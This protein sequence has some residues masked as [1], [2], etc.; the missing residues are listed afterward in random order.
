MYVPWHS[1][2]LSAKQTFPL[3]EVASSSVRKL[4]SIYCQTVGITLQSYYTIFFSFSPN[5]NFLFLNTFLSFLKGNFCSF[6][7]AIK[8]RYH[9][10]L[11]LYLNTSQI[12]ELLAMHNIIF[13]RYDAFKCS[14]TTL[15]YFF[16]CFFF[17]FSFSSFF[18]PTF[19]PTKEQ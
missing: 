7:W 5:D 12:F 9:F 18:V 8:F 2:H 3:P 6:Q 1:Q 11:F 4:F 15:F 13:Y 16:S 17:F 19:P 10:S 14:A